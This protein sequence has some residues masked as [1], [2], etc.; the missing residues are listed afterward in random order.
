[1]ECNKVL[2]GQRVVIG[3]WCRISRGKG[4]D[5]NKFSSVTGATTFIELILHTLAL[6]WVC[7]YML[8]STLAI[9]VRA[10]TVIVSPSLG[11][12]PVKAL[13]C[14]RHYNSNY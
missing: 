13:P 3:D 6:T 5:D 9:H 12:C 7:R 1:M 11:H 4:G 14:Q 2:R 10:I 8:R